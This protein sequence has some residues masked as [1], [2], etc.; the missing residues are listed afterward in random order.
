MTIPKR[1]DPI[2]EIDALPPAVTYLLE[3]GELPRDPK[4]AGLVEA[5]RL[6]HPN[7]RRELLRLRRLWRRRR[8]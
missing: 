1:Q 5:F 4:L 7:R 2:D 6:Q 8:V 3:H